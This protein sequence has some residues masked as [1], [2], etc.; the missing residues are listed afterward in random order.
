[1]FSKMITEE[2]YVAWLRTATKKQ[3]AFVNTYLK[4]LDAWEA[5]QQAGYNWKHP[6]CGKW[7]VFT[8]LLPYIQYKLKQ[9]NISITKEFIIVN[10]LDILSSKD[11]VARQNAL[12]ELA[13][14]YRIQ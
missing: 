10:W 2:E 4:T 11:T 9:A 12:K 1:M 6:R 3:V 8:R 5:F 7:K 13:K 14:L